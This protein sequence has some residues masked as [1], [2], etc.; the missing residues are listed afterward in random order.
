MW[1]PISFSYLLMRFEEIAWFQVDVQHEPERLLLRIVCPR[2]LPP[3][4]WGRSRSG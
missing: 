2:G 3:V 4:G 1:M